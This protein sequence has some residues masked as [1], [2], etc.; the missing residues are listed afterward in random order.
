VHGCESTVVVNAPELPNC[1]ANREKN[2]AP[3]SMRLASSTHDGEWFFSVIDIIEVLTDS[4]NPRDYWY[5]MKIIVQSE[6]G[7][8]PSTVKAGS[9]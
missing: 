3:L 8:Q 7:F 2:R 6:D 5:K 9:T 1:M 4:L